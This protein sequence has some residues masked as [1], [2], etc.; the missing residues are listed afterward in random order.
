VSIE[1]ARF[2]MKK[3]T[4]SSGPL[5]VVFYDHTATMGGGEIALLNMVQRLDRGRYR[6]VVVLGA[7]GPLRQ[8]LESKG[9]ETHVI[10]LAKNV[11]QTRKD[12]LGH[13]SLLRYSA[14]AQ[15]CTY[16]WR[17]ARFFRRRG[18]HLVHTNSLKADILGGVAARLAQVPVIWHVRDR[19]ENDYLP[20][21]V[22]RVFRRLCRILP[23]FIIVN[24][25]ATM[26]T[27]HLP[28]RSAARDTVRAATADGSTRSAK[29]SAVKYNAT[30]PPSAI[31]H[32]G[33][34][35]EE[36]AASSESINGERN[37][38]EARIGLVGRISPWKGQHIFIRAAKEVSMAFPQARFL[39][40]GSP[41]FGED[42]YE[43]EIK[44]LATSLE[45]DDCLEFTGFRDDVAKLIQSLDVLVHAS[46]SG[47]PFGQVIAEGMAAG[48]PVVATRGGAAP[49]IVQDGTTGILIPMGEATP[50]ADAIKELLSDPARAQ[51]MGQAGQQRVREHFTIDHVVQKIEMI[52]DVFAQQGMGSVKPVLPSHKTK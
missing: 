8:E 35:L 10:A 19:I 29:S 7:E 33:V 50:M 52:Y 11:A 39:I 3:M 22:V 40:I 42:D 46:T 15:M 4:S 25:A 41:M 37:R 26:E 49:E 51:Q 31:V 30:A 18:A 12:N 48:K 32:D 5:I 23:N 24:S 44:T 2:V 20:S 6:P 27:L 43:Q 28:H 38:P 14:V 17:L 47:E 16:V 45:L 36:M 9:V 34:V 21:T 1:E 13:K